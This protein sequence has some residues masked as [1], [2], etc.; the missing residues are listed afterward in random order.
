[1][2]IDEHKIEVGGGRHPRPPSLPS[3]TTTNAPP[4]A[5]MNGLH[6]A[7]DDPLQAGDHGLGDRCVYR[8]CLLGIGQ[9]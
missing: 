5:A 2:L 4:D 1:M 6:V 8:A 7:L 3:A 9:P